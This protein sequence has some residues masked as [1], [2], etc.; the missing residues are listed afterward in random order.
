MERARAEAAANKGGFQPLRFFLKP[1][2]EER[3]I[4]LDEDLHSFMG[5]EHHLKH[6]NGKWGNFQSCCNQFA[7]CPIC[8]NYPD[9]PSYRVLILSVIVQ[10]A[11]TDSKGNEHAYSRMLLPIKQGQHERSSRSSASRRRT[12]RTAH[13]AAS[14]CA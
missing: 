6:A 1:D 9:H 14:S 8:E 4:I 12:T 7:D 13:C 2:T 3:I 11:W 10:R 5:N